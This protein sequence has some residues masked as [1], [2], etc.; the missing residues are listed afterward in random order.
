MKWHF[1]FTLMFCSSAF[2]QD[3]NPSVLTCDGQYSD[4]ETTELRNIPFKG[5]VIRIT[6]ENVLLSGFVGITSNEAKQ[7]HITRNTDSFMEFVSM[8]D[9]NFRGSLGR[10]TGEIVLNQFRSGSATKVNKI[11][12][13][14]CVLKERL[15]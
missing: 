6:K 13:G 15:F 10:Y 7:Y 8:N 14:K 3:I 2:S 12:F 9:Q 1:S 4:Y 5:G 11:I